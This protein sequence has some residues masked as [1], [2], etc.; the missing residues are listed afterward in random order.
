MF[1]KTENGKLCGLQGIQIEDTLGCWNSQFSSFE[2]QK[3]KRF[4]CEPRNKT[5]PMKFTIGFR[6]QEMEV[7]ELTRTI[8]LC[9]WKPWNLYMQRN[10]WRHVEK[11]LMGLLG[12]GLMFPFLLLHCLK[13]C[14]PKWT[15]RHQDASLNCSGTSIS[16]KPS[17][18]TFRLG[19]NIHC[20]ICRCVFHKQSWPSI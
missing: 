5:F 20:G 15:A 18:F 8:I 12:N 7:I 17:L 14:H 13:L 3:S 10:C 9:A 16:R 2:N 19:L 6:K 1:R 4:E 11:L